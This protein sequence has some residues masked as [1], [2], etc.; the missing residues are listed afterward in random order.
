MNGRMPS[1]EHCETCK[2]Y[3]QA[4]RKKHLDSP[5]YK[6]KKLIKSC[7]A[8]MSLIVRI[9]ANWTCVKCQRHYPPFISQRSG[10]P[11]Q[12]IMTNSHYFGRGKWGTRFDFNNCDGMCIFCHQ[13]VENNKKE[14]VEGFNYEAYMIAKI[15]EAKLELLRQKSLMRMQYREGQ[16]L[17]LQAELKA[18][19]ETL[20]DYHRES[21]IIIP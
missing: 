11:A 9:K 4:A 18:E 6:K 10:L 13:K 21:E 20:L 3:I 8:L 14:T 1:E 5:Q 19:L 12:N 15:G 7:D 16:L 17:Q 2:A